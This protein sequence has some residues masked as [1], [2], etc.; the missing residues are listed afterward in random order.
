MRGEL[1]KDDYVTDN[2]FSI[3]HVIRRR[4]NMTGGNRIQ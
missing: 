3:P 1:L 4:G 2:G